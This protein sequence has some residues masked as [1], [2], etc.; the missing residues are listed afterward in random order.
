[1][2]VKKTNERVINEFKAFLQN[3]D[4]PC[5]AARAALEKQHIRFFVAEHISCPDNDKEIVK[6]LKEFK[7]DYRKSDSRF[8]SAVIIFREPGDLDEDMFDRFLWK[9]LQDLSDLDS[10]INFYDK[11]VDID[12]S[13][14]NFSF[15]INEEAFFVIGL[16]PG[17]SR[18]AR[19]FNY[20]AL[21]FNPHAQFEE[22]RDEQLYEKMKSIVRKRD[23][24]F[25]GSVN[26]MLQDYGSRSETF[27]YSGKKY[28]ED[29]K[30]PLNIH[31]SHNQQDENNSAA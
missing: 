20:P 24:S 26:P 1:M 21:V 4:F 2:Q 11:R 5:V 27:Q 19:R 9:R 3:K 16:N 23:Q 14:P 13:S 8:H 29:W 18:K 6:F 17:S 28:N 7:S 15:S 25:S 12:P 31:N 30:C 22:L 10:K